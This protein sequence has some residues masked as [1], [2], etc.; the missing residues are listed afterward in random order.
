MWNVFDVAVFAGGFAVCWFGKDLIVK[1]VIG[2]KAFAIKLETKA[3]AIKAA[4]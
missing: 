4:L 2:A 1:T 3:K